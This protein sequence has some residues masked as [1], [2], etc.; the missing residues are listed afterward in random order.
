M[1]S[2][3]K[4]IK[5]IHWFAN[6]ISYYSVLVLPSAIFVA[7]VSINFDVKHPIIP[8]ITYVWM[9]LVFLA[10]VFFL[11]ALLGKII[12]EQDLKSSAQKRG[13]SI[14]AL[15]GIPT[16]RSN[17][18][19]YVLLSI[20]AFI[21]ILISF[22]FYLLSILY[23]VAPL[24]V[25]AVSLGLIAFGLMLLIKRPK[26]P[27]F[28]IGALIDF[29]TPVEFKV[30]VDNLFQDTL[31]SILDPLSYIRFDDWTNYV[32][33]F[34]RVPEGLDQKTALERAV[35]KIFLL[36]SLHI[37]FPK[38]ITRDI[39]R[40]EIA[41]LLKDPSKIDVLENPPSALGMYSFKDIQKFIRRLREMTPE[42]HL[43]VNRLF[44]VL[45][46]NL[47]EFVRGDLYFDVIAPEITKSSEGVS[48]Y[49]FLF[50]NSDEYREKPRPVK[51]RILAA[52][53][54]PRELEIDIT[55]DPK[56]EFEIKSQELEVYSKEKEDV[57]G[58]LSEILQ[59]G[60]G[61]WLRLVPDGYGI[62]T[63][64]VLVEENGRVVR[65]KQFNIM[66]KRNILDIF[67]KLLGSGSILG[68]VGTAI[69]NIIA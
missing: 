2:F 4:I 46:D 31:P 15:R 48:L 24:V 69:T 65:S 39:L 58:K 18:K 16:I 14:F 40:D 3:K 45:R 29:Y 35:E 21:S 49:V 10:F 37:D 27:I 42:I 30:Y 26:L 64:T 28:E 61:V 60:D 12:F 19:K 43:M 54:Y 41:E 50:N 57:I 66:V 8:M 56:G 17:I 32:K 20:L 25:V 11:N 68:G 1:E 7:L 33:Q 9:L 67:K 63:V 23:D 36:H 44:L 5:I 38:I 13:I 47:L 59:L 62:K 51:I 34:I 22:A 53:F 6:N 52:G 55:L